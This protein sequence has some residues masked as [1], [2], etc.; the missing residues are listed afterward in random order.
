[1]METNDTLVL[2]EK[3]YQLIGET[4]AKWLDKRVK[5][6]LARIFTGKEQQINQ[7]KFNWLD[8]ALSRKAGLITSLTRNSRH[9]LAGLMVANDKA[10]VDDIE[11]LYF[12]KKLLRDN[13]FKASNSTYFAAY[14][15][16]SI[17]SEH[18][19]SIVK[20]AHELFQLVKKNHPFIVNMND[21]SMV[22]SLAQSPQL[23]ELMVFEIESLVEFY[24]N[25]LRKI[26]M[27]SNESCL[28]VATLATLMTGKKDSEL[29]GCFDDVV[30]Y[31]EENKI[32]IRNSH[33]I[34][35]ISIAFLEQQTKAVALD[36]LVS[37]IEEV[38]RNISLIFETEFKQALAIS[39]YAEQLS[40][41]LAQTPLTTLS[42]SFNQLI[43]EEQTMLYSSC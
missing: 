21:Y 15:L 29:V 38:S 26:G 10:T 27:K 35:I 23:A 36:E 13:G 16:F 34:P 4:N 39:L 1:M 42:V 20:R 33:Y 32:K 6:L 24:F 14:Q 3:N 22:V 25:H 30:G 37:F 18:R 7:E 5:Y 43:I 11:G 40:N 19:E 12:N 28:I 17:E 41:K 2:L 9:T 31:L 8:V